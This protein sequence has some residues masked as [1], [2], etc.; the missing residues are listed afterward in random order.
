MRAGHFNATGITAHP[1]PV[2]KPHPPIWIGGNTAAARRR[3]ATYGDGWCPFP[4]PAVLAQTARTAAMD[5]EGLAAGID[6]LRRRFDAAGRD[7][8]GI[9]VTFTNP[10]G[11]N[12]GDDDF[13][14]DAY[15]SGVEKLAAVG[16]TWLQ[17][18]LPGDSLAHLLDSIERFGTSVISDTRWSAR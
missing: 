5:S 11:G 8:A 18:S 10:D 12:P 13:N 2:S 4:A 16:V 3:V 9:D 15:L 7:W 1:R 14:A 6:D 17:V